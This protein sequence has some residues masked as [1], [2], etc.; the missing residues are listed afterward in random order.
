VGEKRCFSSG[1]TNA[2][3]GVAISA[4]LL[5]PVVNSGM[6]VSFAL[7]GQVGHREKHHHLSL[8]LSLFPFHFLD[9]KRSSVK[10][11]SGPFR[12]EHPKKERKKEIIMYVCLFDTTAVGA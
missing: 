12:K 10:T 7:L 3:V 8:S 11:G 1:G 6:C 2:L 5:P 4:S 9:S